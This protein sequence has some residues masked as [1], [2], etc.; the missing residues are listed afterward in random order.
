MSVKV[1]TAAKH[2]PWDFAE[3]M[4]FTVNATCTAVNDVNVKVKFTLQQVTKLTEW[5]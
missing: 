3:M 2:K 4:D 1:E 5:K